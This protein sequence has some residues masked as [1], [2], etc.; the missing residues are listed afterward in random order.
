M[1]YLRYLCLLAQSFQHIW[2]CVFILLFFVVCVPYVA[3][4]SL[5]YLFLI[6]PSILSNVYFLFS[7]NISDKIDLPVLG[8]NIKFL[9]LF[10]LWGQCFSSFQLS[11]FCCVRACACV[12]VCAVFIC[13]VASV[14]GMSISGCTLGCLTFIQISLF[15]LIVF[16]SFFQDF[17]F[18]F[19]LSKI[20]YLF[21]RHSI[22]FL[23]ILIKFLLTRTSQILPIKIL[24]HFYFRVSTFA[25]QICY[26]NTFLLYSFQTNKL[27][28][29]YE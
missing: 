18:K 20:Y 26:T 15:I 8:E 5:H 24:L 4:F 22:L 6:A 2:C 25:V 7:K 13:F 27:F 29:Q 19:I 1:S 23:R 14:S 21:W 9:I 10:F 12:C 3:G 28:V 11:V 17:S 16:A